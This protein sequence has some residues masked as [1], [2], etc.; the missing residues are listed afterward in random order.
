[1][2]KRIEC[3]AF[4][5]CSS[6]RNVLL[7]EGLE[8]IGLEAFRESGLKYIAFPPFLRTVHQGAFANCKSLKTA[9]LNEGLE[10][11]GTNEYKNNNGN[12][13]KGVFQGSAIES[14]TLPS[15]LKRIEYSTFC[16]C[17][18]LKNVKLPKGLE[19]I[20]K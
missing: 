11:L 20:G 3:G 17:V 14:V 10:V 1:M 4:Q 5:N 9:V 18:N 12:W 15:T 16:E 2:L 8:E 13:Y 7:P 19:Y 6:L